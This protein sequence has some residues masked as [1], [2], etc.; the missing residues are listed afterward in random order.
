[1]EN[2]EIRTTLN[3]GQW[4]HVVRTWNGS[5]MSLYIDG[6]L[7]FSTN[8]TGTSLVEGSHPVNLGLEPDSGHFNGSLDEFRFYDRPLIC[9]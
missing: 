8:T 3:Q 5:S 9:L 6:V 4:H 7:E 2:T 1:M